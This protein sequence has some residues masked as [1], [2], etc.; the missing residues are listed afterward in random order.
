LSQHY[1]DTVATVSD[2]LRQ[3]ADEVK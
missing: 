3:M 2:E 1:E